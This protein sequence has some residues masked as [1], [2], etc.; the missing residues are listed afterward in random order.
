MCVCACEWARADLEFIKVNIA[1]AI[2][3][4]LINHLPHFLF[5]DSH[6]QCHNGFAELGHVNEARAEEEEGR[7]GRERRREE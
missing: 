4:I 7:G 6:A 1:V 5:S 2:F 3:I